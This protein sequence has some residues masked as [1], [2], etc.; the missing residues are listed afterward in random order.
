M[1]VETNA[2]PGLL[3]P[4]C[5]GI[6]PGYKKVVPGYIVPA[7]GDVVHLK[8]ISR[9]VDD[10]EAVP[11]YWCS[12]AAFQRF[13][14]KSIPGPGGYPNELKRDFPRRLLSLPGSTIGQTPIDRDP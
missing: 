8:L 4:G 13:G 5:D 7:A 12:G 6:S 2:R 10:C 1:L 11:I 9:Q 3:V 14:E